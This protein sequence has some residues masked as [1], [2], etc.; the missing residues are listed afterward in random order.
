LAWQIK[1]FTP[2]KFVLKN[3]KHYAFM[4]NDGKSGVEGGCLFLLGGDGKIS[5]FV[6]S[7]SYGRKGKLC[8]LGHQIVK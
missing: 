8:V 2:S 6:C 5:C 1:N 7:L 3:I 4:M